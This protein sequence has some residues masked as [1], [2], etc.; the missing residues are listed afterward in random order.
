MGQL[1]Y[2]GGSISKA[3][4]ARVRPKLRRL[5]RVRIHGIEFEE[6]LPALECTFEN[7][8]VEFISAWS[9]KKHKFKNCDFTDAVITGT[10]YYGVEDFDLTGDNNFYK[11]HK[12]PKD[13]D[14]EQSWADAFVVYDEL[15]DIP[16]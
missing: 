7:C 6:D 5:V 4:L 15:N 13:E 3:V 16:F 10:D 12:P 14:G 2:T 11:D 1:T 8:R 9:L